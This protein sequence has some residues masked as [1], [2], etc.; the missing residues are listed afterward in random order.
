MGT[1]VVV[2]ADLVADDPELRSW[3]EAGLR[4]LRGE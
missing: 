4:S 2:D 3:L 1:W